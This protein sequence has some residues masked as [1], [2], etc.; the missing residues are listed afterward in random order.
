MISEDYD[1][2]SSQMADDDPRDDI[3]V[4]SASIFDDDRYDMSQPPTGHRKRKREDLSGQNLIEQQHRMYADELLDYF[5][6]SRE[7]DPGTRPEPP[8]NYMPDWH[9]DQ[10]EHTALHWAAAMGDIDLIKQVKR[11][12]ADLSAR[13]IRG[14]TPLIR[15]V[16]FTN[17]QDKQTFPKVVQELISTVK[18]VDYCQSSVLHHA[19]ATCN[20]RM[21]HSCIR[22]YL[23]ILL[24]RLTEFMEPDDFA[25]FLDAQ[26]Q[27]GNTAVLLA[28]KNGARKCVRA[29]IGRGASTNIRNNEGQTADEFIQKLNRARRTRNLGAS[30]SPFAPDSHMS[31]IDPALSE[32]ARSALLSHQSEAANT[33]ESKVTPLLVEKIHELA[34]SFDD[35]MAEQQN[36]E[37]EA[38]RALITANADLAAAQIDLAKLRN[39]QERMAPHTQKM[40]EELEELELEVIGLLERNQAANLK[41][42]LQHSETM[43]D[44]KMVNGESADERIELAK[45]LVEERNRRHQLLREQVE[46]AGKAGMAERGDMYRALIAKCLNMKAD[47]VDDAIDGLIEYYEEERSDSRES[48]F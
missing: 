24:N 14:E 17:C 11:F 35:D 8:A 45:A 43:E 30:S 12:N 29:L 3:T 32:P 46:A 16:M 22:Y 37:R 44:S 6:L 13:N 15:S 36:I 1:Q 19:A 47:E 21:K 40:S 20:S 42:L 5:M 34:K 25:Q 4:D 28:A 2:G 18:E 48:V 27:E 26:D 38:T 39:E 23:D 7:D 9:I 10:E 31:L 33:V 41:S